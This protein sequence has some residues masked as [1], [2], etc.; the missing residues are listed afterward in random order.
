MTP[1][2][3]EELLSH[4]PRLFHMAEVGSW[5]SIQAHGLLSTTALLDAF[6]LSGAARHAIEAQRRPTNVLLQKPGRSPAVV[7]DQMPMDDAGLT[8]CLQD[9]LTPE[10]WYRILNS[11]VFFWLTKDRLVRLLNAAAYRDKE[12]DVLEIDAKSLVQAHASQIWFCPINSGCTKPMPRA[13]G[14]ST[15]ARIEDYPYSTWKKKRKKGERVVE[16]AI[17][18]IVPDIATH[19][20]HVRRMK[21]E[22]VLS[23]IL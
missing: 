16:L 14:H 19:V 22:K 3:L 21:G 2:E 17:D 11:K 4:C 12:H 18:Y 7:R 10:D 8:R 15:F 9:G 5:H 6:S 13:R 20:R 23:E 1:E